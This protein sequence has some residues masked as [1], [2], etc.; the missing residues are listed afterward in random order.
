MGDWRY[1]LWGALCLLLALPLVA[2]Q[3]TKEVVWDL[4]DFLAAGL[5]LGCLG[6][7]VELAFR[8]STRWNIRSL[9]VSIALG[10][11]MLIWADAAVG[12]F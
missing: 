11:V 12:I 5:L 8:A 7:S 10:V 6:G 1:L 3:F 9:I 2:M 4:N